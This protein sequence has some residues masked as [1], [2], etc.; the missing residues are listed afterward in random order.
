MGLQ[1]TMMILFGK[2]ILMQFQYQKQR[3]RLT[4]KIIP[5]LTKGVFYPYNVKILIP[6][7]DTLVGIGQ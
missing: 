7:S 3:I 2:K 4:C 6:T 1:P 5:G